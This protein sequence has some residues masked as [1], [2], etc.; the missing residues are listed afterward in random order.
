M[1]LYWVYSSDD[2]MQRYNDLFELYNNQMPGSGQNSIVKTDETPAWDPNTPTDGDTRNMVELQDED[3]A[4][5]AFLNKEV[6]RELWMNNNMDEWIGERFLRTLPLEDIVDYKFGSD[7]AT[8]IRVGIIPDEFWVNARYDIP[9]VAIDPRTITVDSS[10]ARS[11]RPG[12]DVAVL[13]RDSNT[14]YYF[15]VDRAS[16]TAGW[17]HPEL[18]HVDVTGVRDTFTDFGLE[19]PDAHYEYFGKPR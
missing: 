7:V 17:V 19:H 3:G 1:F 8:G 11:I 2:V 16:Q 18:V 6:V 10:I 13:G 12:S 5:I 15:V 9:D 14:G 4:S